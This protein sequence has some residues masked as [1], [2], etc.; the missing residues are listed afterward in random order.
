MPVQV[1]KAKTIQYLLVSGIVYFVLCEFGVLD[2]KYNLF[3]SVRGNSNIQGIPNV[4]I[5]VNNV[6]T[7]PR[8]IVQYD[9]N[10][11][12]DKG[13]VVPTRVKFACN[14][15]TEVL[16]GT[17][18]KVEERP[19]NVERYKVDETDRINIANKKL[20]S[21]LGKLPAAGN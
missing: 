13:E 19:I 9:T 6:V 17:I 20:C 15:T 10:L 18:A 21:D 14:N 11:Q 1:D 5:E 8:D 16:V 3:L 12:T 2:P 7:F 4:S